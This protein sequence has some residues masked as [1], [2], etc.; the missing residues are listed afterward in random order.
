MSLKST[1]LKAAAA[2]ALLS[3]SVVC[4]G[5]AQAQ[6]ATAPATRKETF[7]YSSIGVTTFCIAS[8]KGVK[9]PNSL[10]IPI[11]VYASLLKNV[12]GSKIAELKNTKPLSDKE[13]IMGAEQQILLR[14]I[15]TCPEF[16]PEDVKK[17][18]KDAFSKMKK[19]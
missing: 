7:L 3:F 18:I 10:S 4:D 9:W 17:R 19:K 6:Q 5:A 2:S 15:D 16:V 12:H 13:L 1:S 14:A 11:E 8:A